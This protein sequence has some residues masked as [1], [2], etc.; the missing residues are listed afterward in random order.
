[1]RNEKQ[2]SQ[3]LKKLTRY[4]INN[5]FH[6]HCRIYQIGSLP[7]NYRPKMGNYNFLLHV[8]LATPVVKR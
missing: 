5:Q 3:P 4:A 7:V 2:S 8:F 6:T 1:M